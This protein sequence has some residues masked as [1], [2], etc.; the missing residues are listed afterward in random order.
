MKLAKI[1][2]QNFRSF[3]DETI[4]LADL[5]TFVGPN[6]TGKS[7]VLTA[8]NIFFR[9]EAGILNAKWVLSEEDFHDKN[10][11]KPIVITLTFN[12]LS[13]AAQEDFKAY[14]RNGELVVSTKAE[15]DAETG[16]AEVGQYG[17]RLVM[18]EFAP[19][20][21]AA[22][23]SEKAEALKKRYAEL[24]S[25]FGELPVAASKGAMI[26][27]LRNYEEAHPD[28]CKL[29]ESSDQFYGWTKGANLLAKYIQ[30]V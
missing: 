6:G 13:P 9:N 21:A 23:E 18:G 3:K 19:F 15:W 30:W 17:S 20:F 25:T 27:A 12:G 5:T 11:A 26:D 2:I 7:N 24:K 1:R 14:F 10:T 28:K 29:R 8:L 4:E 16:G 22:E